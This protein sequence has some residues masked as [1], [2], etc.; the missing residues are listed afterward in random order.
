M[1][2]ELE[3]PGRQIGQ[4]YHAHMQHGAQ[5]GHRVRSPARHQ[6]VP[7]VETQTCHTSA[8]FSVTGH[9]EPQCHLKEKYGVWVTYLLP[10]LRL[11]PWK[12]LR[13]ELMGTTGRWHVG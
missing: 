5:Q 13:Q 4:G 7:P 1:R 8:V 10:S 6:R 2:N 3:P 12:G 9:A 11:L